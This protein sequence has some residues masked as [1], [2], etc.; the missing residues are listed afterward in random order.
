MSRSALEDKALRRIKGRGEVRHAVHAEDRGKLFVAKGIVRADLIAFG[1]EHLDGLGQG[2]AGHGRDFVCGLADDG[3]IDLPVFENDPAEGLCLFF[4]GKPRAAP[5]KF[6]AHF[7]VDF[8]EAD[9]GLFGRAYHAV[10]ER[11]AEQDRV[12]GHADVSALVDDDRRVAGA[13]ADGGSAGAVG[14]FDHARAACGE[15]EGYALMAHEL[16]GEGQR[17]LFNAVD[18]V[19]GSAGLDSG[20]TDD[21]GR[22]AR[23]FR[24]PGV[25]REND[26]VARLQA[27]KGLENGCRRGVGAGDDAGDD[28]QGSGDLA[29]AVDRIVLNDAAGLLILVFM[30]DVLGCEMVLGDLVFHESH[31]RFPDGHARQVNAVRYGSG[32]GMVED[33]VHLLLCERRVLFLRGHDALNHLIELFGR[34][35]GFC[36]FLVH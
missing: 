15:N 34:L 2:D 31:A 16:L 6:L 10:V 11:L 1:D 14:R 22:G 27:E 35:L 28:A 3:G 36:F 7:V 26:A 5:Q 25:G 4:V 20:L 21:F 19:L 24:G 8:V 18:D 30:V 9:H 23:A 33:P 12:H 13:H 32:C 17:G 29:V